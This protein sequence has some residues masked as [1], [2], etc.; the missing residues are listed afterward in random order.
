MNWDAFPSTV[1]HFSH[2]Y[3][4]IVF[5]VIVNT[6]KTKMWSKYLRYLRTWIRIGCATILVNI[7]IKCHALPWRHLAILRVVLS[8][9][10]FHRI[11]LH[12]ILHILF[13]S[14]I[15]S[16]KNFV[17][18]FQVWFCCVLRYHWRPIRFLKWIR[19]SSS[20]AVII[21]ILKYF[22][23]PF[24]NSSTLYLSQLSPIL[25]SFCRLSASTCSTMKEKWNEENVNCCGVS[26]HIDSQVWQKVKAKKPSISLNSFIKF[27]LKFITIDCEKW[28]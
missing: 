18:S 24:A 8:F 26:L 15:E 12:I 25:D 7:F 1:S 6:I 3:H 17:S 23:L 20:Y 11:S 28:S 27:N 19:F 2:V 5:V 22:S 9:F 10:H 21:H 16:V 13:L 4:I 14:F